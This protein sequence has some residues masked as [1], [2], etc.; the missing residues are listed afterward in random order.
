ML[1]VIFS[2]FLVFMLFPINSSFSQQSD[3]ASTLAVQLTNYSPFLYNTEDGYTVIVGEVENTSGFPMTDITIRAFF[4][5]DFGGQPLESIFG[6]TIL[7]VLPP[8]GKSPYVIK[9]QNPDPEIAAPAPP[10]HR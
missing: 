6:T 7:D 3:T 9:S 8:F 10:D 5:D 1:K 2:L 4:Y